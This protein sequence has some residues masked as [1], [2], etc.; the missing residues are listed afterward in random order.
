[1]SSIDSNAISVPAD[2]GLQL[3]P[4]ENEG[5]NFGLLK[6]AFE[7]C[8]RDNQPYI[9]QC[10]LNYET[11]F[12]LWNGQSADGKKHAREGSK[13]SPTPWDGAS[14]L[15]VFLVDNIINKKVAMEVMAFKRA[16]L[17]AVPVESTDAARAQIVSNFMRW[18]IQT[19]IPEVDREIEIFS[20]YAK[21]KGLSAM[22]VFWEKRREKVLV[23]VKLTDLQQQFPQIDVQA[24]IED[25]NAAEDLKMIFTE[26][27]G[28]SKGKASSMLKELRK[29]GETSVPMEGPERSYPII[30]AF[31]LDEQLF[32]PSFSTDLEQAP[33]IYRV[34]YFTAEKLRAMVRDDGWDEE[35][36]EAAIRT[37]R[38]RLITISPSEYLQPISRSFVYTQQRFTDRIGVVFC[39]QRLSDEDGVPG[40]YCTVFH[41]HLPPDS[42]HEGYAKTGLLGYAHGQYP[43]ILYRREYLSRKLHDSRGVPEPGKPW[44][45]Q[46]KAHKDSRIDAASIAILPP[47]CYP[48]GRPPG[49]WG[50]GAM[51]S[52]RRANEYHYADRP[53]PDMNTENSENLLEASFKEY[54]GFASKEGDPSIDPIFNQFEVDKFLSCMAKVF[55]QVWKLYKQYGQDEVMFRVMGVKDADASVFQ[56]GDVNEEFDFYLSWDVQSTDFKKMS[57]KW[58]AI[59]QAAQSLDRDGV[60]DW[61]ALCQM[62]IANIDPNAAERILRPVQAGQQKVVD[63]EHADLAQIFAGI[64]RNIKIGTPPQLG[65]QVM[66]QYLQ[67]P[68]VQQ[69]Y[70]QD[71]NFKERIDARAKQYQQQMVQAQNAQIGRLGAAMPGPMPATPNPR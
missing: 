60:I 34:E 28:C 46:I 4:A 14:D 67:Q 2:P 1:M 49:R 20:N 22:G 8:V 45:D 32:I 63:D 50:P 41:P 13:I 59:I 38:G 33:G 16:N 9:D 35:W 27:Y 19:Q 68:D 24:L 51:I 25:E 62:F 48:Q 31:N 71:K 30:R 5:P 39:Y 43:F 7:D 65:L 17:S 61:S 57:E 21:E 6:K 55:R 26:Q 42:K 52:E 29:N 66:Q 12:A 11:R 15:R 47:I 56:K 40:I 36:V 10:R 58:T 18:L 53:A 44:Q 70:A 23:N 37:Q 3:A 64:P 69:R 54:N